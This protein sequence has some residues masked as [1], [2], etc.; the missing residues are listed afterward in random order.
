MTSDEFAREKGHALVCTDDGQYL[1]A[2]RF[3]MSWAIL[4]YPDEAGQ[5]AYSSLMTS[6]GCPVLKI[7]EEQ[8]RRLA[9]TQKA[10]LSDYEA[11]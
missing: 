10:T 6:L 11:V 9:K 3:D 5:L 7:S 4:W 8:I 1:V 2:V